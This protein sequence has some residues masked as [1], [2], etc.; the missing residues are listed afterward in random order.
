RWS[1][2]SIARQNDESQVVADLQ[3]EHVTDCK[4]MA[5]AR[6]ALSA[7]LFPVAAAS[8][9]VGAPAAAALIASAAS[10]AVALGAE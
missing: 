2:H 6:E 8:V 5:A 1:A 9:A 10:A 3:I 7:I 4:F